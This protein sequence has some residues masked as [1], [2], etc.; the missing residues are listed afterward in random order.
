VIIGATNLRVDNPDLAPN[1]RRVLVTRSGDGVEP[2]ARMFAPELEGEAVVA[3][4]ATMPQEK[5]AALSAHATLVE[6]G[7]VDVDISALLAW[8]TEKRGCRVVLAEGGGVLNERLFAARAVDELH[9][10]LAPRILGGS[11]APTMVEGDGFDADALPD[12]R[13]ISCDRVGDELFLVYEFVW[14]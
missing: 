13:L 8:L 5:R 14:P 11:D 10:T 1:R 12:G 2:S 4:A 7:S 9:L 6:L 3:H